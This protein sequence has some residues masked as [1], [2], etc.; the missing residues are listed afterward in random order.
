MLGLIN[1]ILVTATLIFSVLLLYGLKSENA[2]RDRINRK[3]EKFAKLKK[4][5]GLEGPKG[6]E[7]PEGWSDKGEK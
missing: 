7:A 6:L 2:R 4:I 3:L 1:L 5:E